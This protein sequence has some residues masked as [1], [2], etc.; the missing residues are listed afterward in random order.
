MKITIENSSMKEEP[1]VSPCKQFY[2]PYPKGLH[3]ALNILTGGGGGVKKH[4]NWTIGYCLIKED[5]KM[6][7]A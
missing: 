4:P 2:S 1:S 6:D 5:K 3:N 7:N